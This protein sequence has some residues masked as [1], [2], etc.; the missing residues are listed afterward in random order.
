[1]T[2]GSVTS[3]TQTD[4]PRSGNEVLLGDQTGQST[5]L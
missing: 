3:T 2:V 1:M 5:F 4:V